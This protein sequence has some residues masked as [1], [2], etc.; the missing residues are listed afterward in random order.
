MRLVSLTTAGR[1]ILPAGFTLIELVVT[2][3]LVALGAAM[4]VP[5]FAT[6]IDMGRARSAAQFIAGQCRD[7]RV[8]AVA[9]SAMTGLVFSSTAGV[10][11]FRRC[12]DGN[13]N[14]IRRTDVTS[15]TDHCDASVDITRI[16]TGVEIA[17]S[18]GIPDPDGGSG[19]SDPVRFGASDIASFSATG[20]ATA[21][22]LYVRSAGGAQLAIRIA[23]VTGRTRVLRW[24][25]GARAW[26]EA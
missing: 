6:T 3:G 18:P 17:V 8:Q 9:R 21:G 13:A 20:T 15:G 14:G 7:A 25:T 19:T 24:D 23:G 2:L 12:V 16:F 22:T 26:K 5:V 1:E 4:S 11:T 10:W